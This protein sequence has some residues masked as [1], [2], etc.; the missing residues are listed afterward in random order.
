MTGYREDR[1]TDR[2]P[3]LNPITKN[4]A[5]EA[6]EVRR[7]RAYERAREA[8]ADD[9]KAQRTKDRTRFADRLKK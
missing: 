4:E 7:Q 8:I 6:S 9:L 3:R 2:V 5:A 1:R